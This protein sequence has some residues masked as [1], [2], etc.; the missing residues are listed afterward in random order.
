MQ[1]GQAELQH[2]NPATK[3]NGKL[4]MILHRKYIAQLTPVVESLLVS[5][6]IWW[7]KALCIEKL[8]PTMFS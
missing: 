4:Y 5:K 2:I 1:F 3:K 8:P 7:T 6:V